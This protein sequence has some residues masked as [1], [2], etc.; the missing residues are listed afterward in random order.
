[1]YTFTYTAIDSNEKVIQGT[2]RA[3]DVPALLAKLRNKGLYVTALSGKADGKANIGKLNLNLSLTNRVKLKDLVIFSR[4]FATMIGAGLPLAACLQTLSEQTSSSKLKKTLTS[5]Q[6]QVEN[7]RSL[8]EAMSEHPEVFS[9][10]YI[11]MVNAGETGGVLEEML[12]RTATFIEREKELR[13]KVKS[14]MTYPSAILGF[15]L[16]IT[17]GI[18]TF[19]VP[20]FVKIYNQLNAELPAPTQILINISNAFRSVWGPIILLGLIIFIFALKR[21]VST[22]IG[23]FHFDILK[24]NIPIF[25]TIIHKS[26]L[27]RFARTFST[28]LRGGVP[29]MEVI[30]VTAEAT[31]NAVIS[32]ASSRIRQGIKGGKNLVGLFRENK[33]FPTMMVQMIS[34]GEETGELDQMLSKVADFYEDEVEHSVNRL[35]SLI[36]P[37]MMMGL[38]VIVGGVVI[39]MYLPIFDIIKHIK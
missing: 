12:G 22:P 36:E 6:T 35:T 1:M 28:L 16:L 37:V 27:S 7:G 17:A 23:R 31:D 24:L 25:G 14:A 2:T 19:I 30:D 4:E 3:D 5:I 39:S 21:Y 34:A 11:N 38:A 20:R 10:L 15:A 26:V 8:S 33:I 9:P 18:I 13:D 29:I 32:R